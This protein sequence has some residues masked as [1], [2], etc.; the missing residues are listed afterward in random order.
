MNPHRISGE[1]RAIEAGYMDKE[2]S[3]S[4]AFCLLKHKSV[5]DGDSD[6]NTISGKP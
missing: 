2:A 1:G 3:V 6:C 4:P 5:E